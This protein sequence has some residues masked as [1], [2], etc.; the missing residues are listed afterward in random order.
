MFVEA[1]SSASSME[2]LVFSI[3]ATELVE[4]DIMASSRLVLVTHHQCSD[5]GY[6]D[7][8]SV[9]YPC[10][11][12]QKEYLRLGL[13][14]YRFLNTHDGVFRSMTHVSTES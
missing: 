7:L 9:M 6:G 11:H 1:T 8:S 3:V 10:W 5:L 12:G 13:I 2:H 4:A 14:V